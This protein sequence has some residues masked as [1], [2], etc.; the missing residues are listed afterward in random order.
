LAPRNDIR[1]E[2]ERQRREIMAQV[3]QAKGEAL[4]AASIAAARAPGVPGAMPGLGAEASLGMLG[5]MGRRI[6]EGERK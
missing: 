6:A 2:I 3:E 4:R 1:A 5:V